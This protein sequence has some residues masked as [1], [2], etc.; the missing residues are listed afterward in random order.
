MTSP[1]N[2]AGSG[3]RRPVAKRRAR[4]GRRHELADHPDAT[5]R[6]A[7]LRMRGGDLI[8]AGSRLL[9]PLGPARGLVA[10]DDRA[11][12]FGAQKCSRYIGDSVTAGSF[13]V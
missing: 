12:E 6:R 8:Q 10:G 3:R 5:G 13:R 11:N 2:P 9:T 1:R 4:P 7:D